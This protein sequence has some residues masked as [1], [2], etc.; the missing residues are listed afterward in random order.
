MAEAIRDDVF[1]KVLEASYY[2]R[3]QAN[4]PDRK[5]PN[6]DRRLKSFSGYGL[7]RPSESIS[8]S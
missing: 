6:P 8:S 7:T 5:Y 2:H 1:I 3:G 4:S